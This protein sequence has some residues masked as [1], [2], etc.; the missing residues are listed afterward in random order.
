M[1][2]VRAL[3]SSSLPGWVKLVELGTGGLALADAALGCELLVIVDAIVSGA[4]AGTIRL[5]EG[6]EVA[7]AVHLGQGHEPSVPEALALAGQ[8]L[9]ADMPA[10][11]WVVAVEAQRLTTF[12]EELSPPV[13]AAVP[14]AAAQVV[15]LLEREHRRAV[16]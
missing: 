6:T 7:R 11:V 1:H 16:R 15:A 2:V 8:L 5:L 4:P 13:A 3:G 12:T 10:R 9:G 14:R